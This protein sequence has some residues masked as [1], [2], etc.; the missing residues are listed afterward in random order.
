MLC[1]PSTSCS[2]HFSG[3]CQLNNQRKTSRTICNISQLLFP[4]LFPCLSLLRLSIPHSFVMSSNVHPNCATSFLA[5]CP[6][7]IW[8]EKGQCNSVPAPNEYI[9]SSPSSPPLQNSTSFTTDAPKVV[10]LTSSRLALKFFCFRIK[11]VKKYFVT[12]FQKLVV[13]KSRPKASGN[14]PWI[15]RHRFSA[16]GPQFAPLIGRQQ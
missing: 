6:P 14:K 4:R 9:S 8:S 3:C 5:L 12:Y 13:A 11:Y 1:T 16:H 15:T 10:L 7:A 2:K